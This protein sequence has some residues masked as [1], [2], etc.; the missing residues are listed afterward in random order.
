VLK[1]SVCT[2]GGNVV[3][4]YEIDGDGQSRGL[5]NPSYLKEAID[6]LEIALIQ[7]KST[8]GYNLP[9]QSTADILE[10]ASIA[11]ERKRPRLALVKPT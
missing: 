2:T 3:W 10:A 7:A 5:T 11:V 8:L 4:E 6:S 9:S 1:I